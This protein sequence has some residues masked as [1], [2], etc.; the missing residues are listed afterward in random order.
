VFGAAAMLLVAAA[1]EGF[2]SASDLPSAVKR[3]VGGV[4]FLVVAA[5]LGFAG[6]DRA[7]DG[8]RWT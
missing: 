2:W 6:R 5:Y 1:V 3:V 8:A 7:R 4:L